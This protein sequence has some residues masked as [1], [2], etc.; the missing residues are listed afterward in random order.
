MKK[1]AMLLLTFMLAIVAVACSNNAST[2]KKTEAS[3]SKTKEITIKHKL[4]ETK[5][6]TNPKNV[7]VFD[8]GSLDTLDKLGVEVAGVPQKNVPEYLSKY[9]DKKYTNVGGL[10]E[11]DFEKINEMNP[12]LIII[13]GR[14]SD[15]YKEFEKIAPTIYVE[16]D[17]KDYMKSFKENTEMLAKIFDKEDA[18]KKEIAAVEKDV[19]A[20]NEKATKSDKK[21]LILLANDGQVSAYGPQSRFG[22]IHDVF[23]VKPVD[24]ELKADTHGNKVS[25]EYI[26]EKNPDYIFVV[27]RGAVVGGKSSAKQVVENEIVSKTNAAKNGNV[28]YLDANY[29]YL[30]GGGLESVSEMVKEVSKGLK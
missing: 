2:D 7:V 15:S 26:L 24:T 22:I 9:K 12:E 8:F 3:E 19:K 14:Q 5:V 17:T 11:P 20:L 27:D 29:W 18:A 21:G 4:G 10:K 6:K 1:L 13:S 30:S 23:G 16:Q 28:V 25:F